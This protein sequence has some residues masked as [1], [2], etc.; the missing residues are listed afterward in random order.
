M[1]R[2]AGWIYGKVT[3]LRNTLYDRGVLTSHSLGARTISIGN[4]TTGGTGKTPL[5]ALVADILAE[6][7]E[8]VCVLTRGYGRQSS[9][10]VLVSDGENVL[11]DARTG[12][13]EPVELAGE[14]I[15]KAVVVADADRIS[16]AAWAKER[17]G[18]TAFVLDD[19]FQHRRAKR[20]LDIVCIDA[21]NP[22]GNERMLPAGRLREP[23]P[24]LARA[25][26]IVITR[27]DLASDVSELRSQ[28]TALNPT[29]AIFL[30]RTRITNIDAIASDGT[31]FAFCGLANPDNFFELLRR[32]GIG[33]NGTKAFP[34]HHY[35]TQEE[36]NDLEQ[37]AR[38]AG[39]AKL[40]TT[41]KDSVKLRD[42][43]FDLP[44][45][46]VEIRT[47]VDNPEAF[48][49]MITSS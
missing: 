45:Q 44:C 31:A 16:A 14:L 17:F 46:E 37:R 4:I 1:I 11:V 38:Q 26:A 13:D 12:G 22:F 9:G 39:A 30:A 3:D 25:S 10:R 35:Y 36:I 2:A 21:T 24:N 28:A 49:S 18:I 15:G 8:K 40:L 7:G 19:A 41:V 32:Y 42:L 47:E 29:A 23:L 6:A 33:L 48:R 5:V 34:D 27:S 43:R 20:D